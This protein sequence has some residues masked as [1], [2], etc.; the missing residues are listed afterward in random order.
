[1]IT[2]YSSLN[3]PWNYAFDRDGTEDFAVIYDAQGFDL[4]RSEFF[5]IP[6]DHDPVPAVLVAVRAMTAA[7]ELLHALELLL[8]QTVEISSKHGI[9]L[10]RGER[11]IKAK[12]IKAIQKARGV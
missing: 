1:M 5:W 8:K 6:E 3:G 10:S 12:A 11:T 7:P 4:V 9:R 2:N